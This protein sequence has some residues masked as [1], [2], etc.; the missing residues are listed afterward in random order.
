[1]LRLPTVLLILLF[2]FAASLT[3]QAAGTPLPYLVIE[4]K[5]VPRAVTQRHRLDVTIVPEG[6]QSAAT[7]DDLAAT[8]MEAAKRFQG[9]SG[10]PVVTVNMLCQKAVNAWG[11]DQ[12]AIAVYIPDG[13]GYDGKEA[14]GPWDMVMAAPRGFTKQELQY[15]RLWAEMRGSFQKGGQTDEEALDAAIS[16]KMGVE[17][18]TLEPHLNYL[19]PVQ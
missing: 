11:E 8:V 18:E 15:L 7:Q 1:M 14:K 6:D 2:L 9:E 12:L 19:Q 4:K 16:K 5:D 3:A 17:P 13:K 10:V